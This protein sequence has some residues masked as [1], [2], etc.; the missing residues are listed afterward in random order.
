MIFNNRKGFS[1]LEVMFASTIL[2]IVLVSLLYTYITCFE[3]NEFS[4]NL[5]LANNALQGQMEL[6][7]ETPFANLESTWDGQTFTLDGFTG[8]QATGAIEVYDIV[9]DYTDLKYVRLVASWQQVSGR[10]VG[11]DTNLDGVLQ[12]GED[13][14]GNTWMD[15]PAELVVLMPEVI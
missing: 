14:N 9:A 10:I 2:I 12:V 15:S 13:V 11:E 5:T 3:L 6:I 1:L 7:R 4:R 8:T